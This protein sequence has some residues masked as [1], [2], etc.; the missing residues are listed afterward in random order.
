MQTQKICKTSNTCPE[1]NYQYQS[2]HHRVSLSLQYP[3]QGQDPSN[4]MLPI[5]KDTFQL[6]DNNAFSFPCKFRE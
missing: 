3:N 4:D 5:P 6:I 2:V 1:K